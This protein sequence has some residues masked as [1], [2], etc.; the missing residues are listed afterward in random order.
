M[1]QPKDRKTAYHAELTRIMLTIVRIA[2]DYIILFLALVFEI[3]LVMLR[4]LFFV[5]VIT[6]VYYVAMKVAWLLIRSC[7]AFARIHLLPAFS[8]FVNDD[9]HKRKLYFLM[10]SASPSPFGGWQRLM[11]FIVVANLSLA[12][13]IKPSVVR[14]A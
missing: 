9:N 5:G 6:D 2:K 1:S 4:L 14:Q 7:T 13:R 3:V 8:S 12:A 11:S 10:V